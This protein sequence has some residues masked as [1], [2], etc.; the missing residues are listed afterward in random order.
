MQ[1]L[2]DQ[3]RRLGHRIGGAVREHQFCLD[4]SAHRI[5]DE[6]EQRLQ[7]AGCDLRRFR[8]DLVSAAEF[9]CRAAAFGGR[10]CAFGHQDLVQRAGGRQSSCW[11][12]STQL[13][14]SALSSRFQNGAL[15]LR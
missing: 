12:G 11:R 15:A 7:F 6:I 3:E 5:A 13:V 8:R 14:P 10:S 4:E 1:R 9:R 2:A